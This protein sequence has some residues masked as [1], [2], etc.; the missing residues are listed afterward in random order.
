MPGY[1]ATDWKITT[2]GVRLCLTPICGRAMGQL[3]TVFRD[4]RNWS[5]MQSKINGMRC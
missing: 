3:I 1:V 4:M 5:F 2:D